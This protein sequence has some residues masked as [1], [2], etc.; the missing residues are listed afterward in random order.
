MDILS[1]ISGQNSIF[2]LT[3]TNQD[4]KFSSYNS[5][6]GSFVFGSFIKKYEVYEDEEEEEEEDI[7]AEFEDEIR[8]PKNYFSI[9]TCGHNIKSEALALSLKSGKSYNMICSTCH[10]H[11][12]YASEYS[13]RNDSFILVTNRFY[14]IDLSAYDEKIVEYDDLEEITSKFDLEKG[15]NTAITFHLWSPRFKGEI[16]HRKIKLDPRRCKGHTFRYSTNGWG[17]IQLYFGGIEKSRLSYSHI[18]HFNEKGA[19]LREG[20]NNSSGKVKDWDWQ[21]IRKTSRKLKYQIHNKMSV[22][23]RGSMGIM[24]GAHESIKMGIELI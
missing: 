3:I 20:A 19:L 2:Y 6:S 12:T 16:I 17:L 14:V 8:F 18:G 13:P 5:R 10:H 1:S 21:E 15:G 4:V 7:A 24:Q 11:I 23:K 9:D 22:D